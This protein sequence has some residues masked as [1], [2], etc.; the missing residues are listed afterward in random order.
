[1]SRTA[2][3]RLKLEGAQGLV[4]INRTL[5][6]AQE[7]VASLGLG[8]A[9]PVTEMTEA[10]RDADVVI[11]ST[12]AMHFVLTPELIA[13]AMSGRSHRPLFLIDIAVPRDVDPAVK[14]QRA[15][16]SPTSTS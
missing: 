9:V 16:F 3:K 14:A 8:R 4:V 13:D 1:M 5:E 2:A 11:S 10:L 6:R 12:G 7:L 15:S